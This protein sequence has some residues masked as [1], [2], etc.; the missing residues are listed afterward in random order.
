MFVQFKVNNFL[1]FKETVTFS[2]IGYNPIKEHETDNDSNAVFDY[3]S[4]KIKILKSTVLYGANGSG[5]SNLI[6]AMSF[7]KTFILTSSNENQVDDE[8][9][10]IPFLLSTQTTQLPSSFE[11]VFYINETRYRYG[12]EVDKEKIHKEWLF[13]L[14]NE[15]SNKETKLFTREF[16]EIKFNKLFFKEGK[17]IVEKTRQNALFLSTISQFNGEISMKILKWFKKDFNIISGLESTTTL[18]TISKFQ[19]EEEFKTKVINFFKSIKIGFDN[20]EIGEEDNIIEKS[21]E[22]FINTFHKKFNDKNQFLKY[23]MIDFNLESKG[24][25]KIFSLLGPIIDTIENGKILVVDELDSRLHTLLTIELIKLFHLKVN[26]KAQIIFT[27]H[28]TNLLKK[29]IFRRDQI[30]FVE[31]NEMGATDLSSLVEFKINQTTVR[32]D[33][34][35]EKD[36]L[37]GKYGAIPFLGDIQKFK[38]DF[39]NGQ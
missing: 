27:S 30:W 24:T 13:T 35:F 22:V 34:S 16:Q 12:F 9:K 21:T 32:N 14:Q 10:I 26:K 20:I 23:E 3:S 4:E 38:T 25:T 17:G 8:I 36:Y 11:M 7:F 39:L 1:S 5:K 29:E 6:K 2:M 28:D 37:L 18:Y 19:K 33:A 15:T 31:K